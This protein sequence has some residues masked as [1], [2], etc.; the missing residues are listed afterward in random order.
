MTRT[1]T[2]VASICTAAAV[3]LI[4]A[5]AQEA[6]AAPITCPAGQTAQQVSPGNFLCVNNGGN[7]DQSGQTKNPND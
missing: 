4:G 6:S 3:T 1:R 5:G 2:V 7:A